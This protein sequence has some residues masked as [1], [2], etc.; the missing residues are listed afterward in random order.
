[1]EY[2]AMRM[3]SELLTEDSDKSWRFTGVRAVLRFT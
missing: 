2:L 3:E 1:M